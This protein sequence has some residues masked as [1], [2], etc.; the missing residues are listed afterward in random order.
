[1][2]TNYYIF[3]ILSFTFIVTLLGLPSRNNEK[4]IGIED[5]V[6]TAFLDWTSPD[7]VSLYYKPGGTI[8]KNLLCINDNIDYITMMDILSAND[9]MYQVS[10]Y[11]GG[12]DSIIGIGWIYKNAPIRVVERLY[13]PGE[14]L[15]VYSNFNNNKVILSLNESELPESGLL[16]VIDVNTENGWIKI[17]INVGSNVVEGWISPTSYCGNPYTTCG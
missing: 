8:L 11:C 16:D 2:K 10:V 6:V 17:R 5:L 4:N 12:I 7:T 3:A 9:S 13:I 14:K 15:L 1:M